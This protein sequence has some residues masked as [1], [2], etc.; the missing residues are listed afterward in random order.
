MAFRSVVVP[1]VAWLALTAALPAPLS[2]SGDGT[3]SMRGFSFTRHA[4]ADLDFSSRWRVTVCTS[5]RARIRIRAVFDSIDFGRE[6]RRVV[7]HQPADCTRHRLRFDG[8]QWE[9]GTD[10]RLRVA[11]RD[12]RR[13]SPWLSAGDPAPD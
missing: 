9:G 1:V 8:P 2:A 12:L 10:S 13:R 6:T 4:D 5:S 11:W 3:F 7:R